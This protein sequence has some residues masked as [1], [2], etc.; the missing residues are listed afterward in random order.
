MRNFRIK[1][2]IGGFSLV[3]IMVGVGIAMVS[4]LVIM[5]VF[6]LF[7]GQKRTTTSGADAQT[8]GGIATYIVE[9]DV[10]MAGYGMGVVGALGCTVNSNYNG[11]NIPFS[12]SPVVITNGTSGLPDSIRVMASSKT[13][14]SVPARITTDHP[15]QATNMFLNTTHGIEVNDLLVAYQPGKDCTLLQVTGIPNGN[16]QIHHQNTSPWNPPGGQNIFP[17]PDGYTTGAMLFN[18]GSMVNHTYSIDASANLQ[19]ADFQSST[20]TTTVQLLVSNIVQLQA[21]Y[22][23]DTRVGVQTDARVDT[24]SDTMIDADASGIAG[25]GG[26]IG[27]IYAI[28]M[29]LVARSAVKEKPQLDGTC[30]I[31]TETSSNHPTWTPGAIDVS[32]NPD[33]TA[34]ADWKCFRYKVFET[35][36]PL[37]NLLWRET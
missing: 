16:V 21:Q 24:W 13:S 3:E 29:A 9:R 7:E 28:R 23:F 8:D 26:D 17:Q 14:F 18:L 11:T 15:P 36:V 6:A 27:R 37:R 32:K 25:D 34:N 35:V 5:Q 4:S 22:G 31:T 20:N 10:R 2:D 30:N 19:L 33:G 1:R 12:L